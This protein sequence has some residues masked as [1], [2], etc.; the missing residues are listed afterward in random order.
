[1]KQN[2]NKKKLWFV[3]CYGDQLVDTGDNTHLW[4]LGYGSGPTF[5][6]QIFLNIN[7]LNLKTAK[8]C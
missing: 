7:W 6:N 8:F 1:M 3:C 2:S 5:L 4:L